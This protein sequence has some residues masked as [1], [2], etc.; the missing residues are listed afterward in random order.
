MPRTTLNYVLDGLT[1]ALTLTLVCTG[2]MMRYA[3]PPGT[4]HSLLLWGLSR[5]QW[6]DVHFYVAAAFAVVII[7][8]VA[9]H[10][11]WVCVMT[12]QSLAP[13][14]QARLSGRTRAIAGAVAMAALALAIGGLAWVSTGATRPIADFAGAGT[15]SADARAPGMGSQ[16]DEI[17][18]SMTLR[19]VSIASAVPLSRL[20]SSLHV[21]PAMQDDIR[22]GQLRR[23]LGLS[24]ADVRAAVNAQR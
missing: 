16:G 6:G 13:R 10:W 12:R 8:H 4:G 14:S 23:E 24:M 17:R 19:E 2:V 22:I 11:Q 9:L 20:R 15:L 5:H 21:P 18:G 3:L 7:L 1:A